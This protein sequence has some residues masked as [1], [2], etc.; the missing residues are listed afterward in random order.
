MSKIEL[1]QGGILIST[2]DTSILTMLSRYPDLTVAE[3][4]LHISR[5]EHEENIPLCHAVTGRISRDDLSPESQITFDEFSR[6]SKDRTER[7]QRDQRTAR[8]N[9]RRNRTAERLKELHAKG[10][11]SDEVLL[12]YGISGD[13]PER[14]VYVRMT[15]EEKVALWEQRMRDRYGPDWHWQDHLSFVPRWWRET[16]QEDDNWLEEGF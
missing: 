8:Y 12:L 7:I 6:W 9:N 13:L 2:N 5:I 14:N 1:V 10:I 4:N 11:V 16:V 15:R 3:Q